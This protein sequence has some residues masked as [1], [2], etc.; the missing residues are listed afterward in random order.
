MIDN[1]RTAFSPAKLC[2]DCRRLG[3]F[4]VVSF[5]PISSLSSLFLSPPPQIHRGRG[6]PVRVCYPK[7]SATSLGEPAD[8]GFSWCKQL[9]RLPLDLFKIK[10][11]HRFKSFEVETG[12]KQ[13]DRG[14]R[15]SDD[16]Q[17][18]T[19]PGALIMDAMAWANATWCRFC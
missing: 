5:P 19:V 3:L 9:D 10:L 2:R 17:I 4:S 13:S 8:Q 1:C 11:C 15:G 12:S 14:L 6:P 18:I 7:H 16:E